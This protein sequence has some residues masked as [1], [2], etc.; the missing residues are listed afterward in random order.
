MLSQ[1]QP[2]PTPT[3]S[4]LKTQQRNQQLQHGL[5]GHGVVFPHEQADIIQ[6]RMEHYWAKFLPD[7]PLENWLFIR[8]CTESVQID[9]LLHQTIAERDEIALRA[10]ESWDVDRLLDARILFDKLHKKP[11]IVQLQLLQTKQGCEVLIEAWEE[12]ARDTAQNQ[13]QL[14]VDSLW[15]R[16]LNLLGKHRD[17][18]NHCTIE[19]LLAKAGNLSAT[20]WIA[21]QIQSLKDRLET[22]LNERDGRQRADTQTGVLIQETPKLKRLKRDERSAIYRMRWA[23]TQLRKIQSQ[24]NSDERSTPT[25][26]A[27]KPSHN[28]LTRKENEN[29]AKNEPNS[30]AK[31]ADSIP[32]PFH[33]LSAYEVAMAEKRAR[34]ALQNEPKF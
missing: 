20:D 16:V 26:R 23:W 12:I 30:Q 33:E 31:S 6:E 8:V 21:Q 1:Q 28:H 27:P 29:E 7:S 3:P 15:P 4:E 19:S 24:R 32:R 9:S 11:E 25:H 17:H 13:G 22:H 18:R 14:P 2:Q 5:D 34:Q 10:D